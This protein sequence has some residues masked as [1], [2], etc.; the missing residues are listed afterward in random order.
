V[1]EPELAASGRFSLNRLLAG[2][3]WAD[4]TLEPFAFEETG[5]GPRGRSVDLFDD[6]SVHL[7]WVP[8][9]AE[10]QVAV[11]VRTGAGTVLLASDSVYGS[12]SLSEGVPPG[13]VTDR[14]AALESLAWVRPVAAADDCVAVLANHDPDVEPGHVDAD[15]GRR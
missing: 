2:H 12:R 1:S 10:G 6:G 8:G 11:L 7:V 15:G 3:M 5:L 4:A 9:H 13:A 14:G